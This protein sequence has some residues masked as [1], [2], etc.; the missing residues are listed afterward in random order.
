PGRVIW[1]SD[2]KRSN[3]GG[4]KLH[5]TP[6]AAPVI[7]MGVEILER[8]LYIV[9]ETKYTYHNTVNLSK[10]I[11]KMKPVIDAKQKLFS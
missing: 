8:V 7:K 1:T 5:E 3:S 2:Q 11:I 6:V 10:H 9:H 4:H